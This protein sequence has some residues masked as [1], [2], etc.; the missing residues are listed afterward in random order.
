VNY[1]DRELRKDI[2]GF[3]RE[4]TCVIRNVGAGL[5]RSACYLVWH[6]YQK[7]H[8]VKGEFKGRKDPCHAQV[9]GVDQ[10]RIEKSWLRFFVDR[11]FSSRDPVP[12][13]ARAIWNR[14]YPTPLAAK[15]DYVPAFARICQQQASG[16]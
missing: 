1:F 4:T 15:A 5:L 3:R 11:P 14:D 6:N 9:A 16:F 10:Q 2:A 12:E 8:R 13:W 7:P